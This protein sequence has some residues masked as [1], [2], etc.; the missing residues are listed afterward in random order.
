M[1]STFSFLVDYNLPWNFFEQRIELI[2]HITL[3]DVK[4][5]V[6]KLLHGKKFVTVQVSSNY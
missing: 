1:N 2:K 4:K 3:D 5:A 6:K